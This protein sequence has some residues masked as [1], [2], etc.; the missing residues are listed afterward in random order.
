[1]AREHES[2][3]VWTRPEETRTPARILV[4]DDDQALQRAIARALEL[5]GYDV[6]VASDGLEAL[7]FFDG[8]DDPDLVV[9]DIL[10]PMLDGLA[11]CRALRTRSRVPI[12]ILTARHDVDDRVEGLDAGADDYLGKPFAVV[13]L[14]ARVRALLRR[15]NPD[16]DV[17]RYDDLELDRSE[18]RGRRAGRQ[19]DLTR[20]EFSL[21][22]LLMAN[23]HRVLSR[24]M[25]FDSVWGY[26]LDFA[27][28]SLEVYIGYLRRKTEEAGEPRLIQ[29]VRGVGYVLRRS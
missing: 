25:I 8:N 24:Q 22:E 6:V 27:S 20:I 12:L 11:T 17:L 13:E 16:D 19:F 14:A 5:E 2:R 26:D 3:T 1:M 23:P 10:M 18:R 15:A 29:T 9:L 4:A 28:N 7:E 21:L